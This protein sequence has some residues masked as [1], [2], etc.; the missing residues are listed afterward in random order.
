[1][2]SV[3]QKQKR[4]MAMSSNPKGRARLRK[5]GV[6]PAP[7]SVAKEWVAA[8]ARSKKRLPVRKKKR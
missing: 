4:F 5:F 1:M 3:S 2:P 7:M 8:D 6:K